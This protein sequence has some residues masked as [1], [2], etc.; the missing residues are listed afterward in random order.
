MDQITY[1]SWEAHLLNLFTLDFPHPNNLRAVS[2]SHISD[3][4]QHAILD[5]GNA[6]NG[7]QDILF[8]P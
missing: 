7:V 4:N 5:T 3:M 8:Y 1:F 2:F 6:V